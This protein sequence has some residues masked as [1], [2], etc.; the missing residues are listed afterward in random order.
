MTKKKVAVPAANPEPAATSKKKQAELPHMPAKTQL[1]KDA[2]T[3][4]E[5]W[6]DLQTKKAALSAAKVVLLATMKKTGRFL[7]SALDSNGIKRKIEYK[8]TEGINVTKASS[9][10]ED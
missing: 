8:E 2:D 10:E 9:S 6:E 4:V 1:E 3:V 5:K 7:V